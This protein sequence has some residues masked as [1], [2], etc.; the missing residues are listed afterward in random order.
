MS[1]RLP[2]LD[3]IESIPLD[4]DEPESQPLPG[5]ERTRARALVLPQVDV[6]GDPMRTAEGGDRGSAEFRDGEAHYEDVEVDQKREA[7]PAER[8]EWA[9]FGRDA[10]LSLQGDRPAYERNHARV[11]RGVTDFFIG[12]SQGTS[13]EY[14]GD[15]AGTTGLVTHTPIL[16][17]FMDE[18]RGGV[19]SAVRGTD[20][21]T[22]RDQARREIDQAHEQNPALF[23]TGAAGGIAASAALP[24][25][26]GP[27]TTAMGRVGQG[28]AT[29][30]GL[31]LVEGYARS[32][33]EDPQAALRDSLQGGLVGGVM[34]AGTSGAIEG[35]TAIPGSVARWLERRAQGAA[36][37]GIANRLEASGVSGQRALQAAD[38]QFGGPQV[39]R[40]ELAHELRQRGIGGNI[41]APDRA[42]ED[43]VALT[44]A[45]GSQVGNSLDGRPGPIARALDEAGTTV[46]LSRVADALESVAQRE[47]SLAVGGV[48]NQLR[49]ELIEPLRAAG[50]VSFT[51]AHQQRQA[52][53]RLIR[54][55]TQQPSLAEAAGRIREA[56]SLIDDAMTSSAQQ[57]APDLARMWQQSNRDT[58]IGSFLQQFG[59]GADR[60]QQGGGIS[61]AMAD[62]IM[63]AEAMSGNPAAIAGGAASRAVAQES[64]R[65]QP[66]IRARFW[67][68][69]AQRAQ[70]TADWLTETL[71]TAPQA[72]GPYARH[73]RS[74]MERGFPTDAVATVH[75]LLSQRDPEYRATVERARQEQQ[76]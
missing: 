22:E 75:F 66:G 47:D 38:Q 45:A 35:A 21:R 60:A 27:A 13:G 68:G 61:G 56:R 73:F 41:P 58:H 28:F 30:T 42:A 37:R 76:R 36:Q 49:T 12:S 34:G 33:E 46:D 14:Q 17:G 57:S 67:E 24:I 2:P 19:R 63:T 70:S 16:G 51:G 43:A 7:P 31:G 50:Q 74:A 18:I 20:Y 4:E 59:R 1:E 65:L 54:S 8:N 32:E 11:D 64:R 71:R 6:V 39:G 44:R 40:A 25:P 10:L 55:W 9:E 3:D 72:L 52:L 29:G 5:Y 48:G 26:G 23:N 62:G 15:R 53:D 69:T